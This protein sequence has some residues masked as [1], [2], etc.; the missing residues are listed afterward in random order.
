MYT[1][2]RLLII[3]TTMTA[4]TII[5]RITAAITPPISPP[6]LL[7]DDDDSFDCAFW[8]FACV[9]LCSVP[10]TT[11]KLKLDTTRNYIYDVCF[12]NDSIA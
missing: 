9:M 4:P 8:S 10:V 3:I 7:S 11:N 1:P 2:F 5:A 12:M 6:L